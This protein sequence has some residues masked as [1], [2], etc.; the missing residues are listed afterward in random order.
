TNEYS[1]ITNEYSEI[2]NEYS[3]IANAIAS[4]VEV[5]ADR[6]AQMLPPFDVEM[7]HEPIRLCGACYGKAPRHRK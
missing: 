1:E 2:A 3:E 6:L 4:V 5:D 7:Q